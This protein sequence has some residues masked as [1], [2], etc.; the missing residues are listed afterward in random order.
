MIKHE[1]IEKFQ[2]FD[3]TSLDQDGLDLF[4]DFMRVGIYCFYGFHCEYYPELT[5]EF[6]ANMWLDEV[7]ERFVDSVVK[8]RLNGV[9]VY[10]KEKLL[11]HIFHLSN[12][13]ERCDGQEYY[14]EKGEGPVFLLNLDKVVEELLVRFKVQEN[15][16]IKTKFWIPMISGFTNACSIEI[17]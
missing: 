15:V 14:K 11:N 5:R 9:E 7:D 1:D 13:R 2:V 4:T 3:Y 17:W 10:V 16:E 12:T 8:S 6:Y